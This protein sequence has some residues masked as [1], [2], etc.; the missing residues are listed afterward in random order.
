MTRKTYHWDPES[1]SMVEGR[2]PTRAEGSGDGWRFSDRVY[3]AKPFLG[4]DGTVIHSKKTHREYMKKH[5]L[6]TMDDFTGVWA[7]KAEE[8]ARMYEGKPFDTAA[9]REAVERAFEK[10]SRS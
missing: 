5:D 7:K 6:T 10:H 2:G 1:K 8:R 4:H 9:R 3:S